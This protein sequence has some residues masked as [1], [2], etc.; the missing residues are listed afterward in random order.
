MAG[1]AALALVA[2]LGP[3]PLQHGERM[4]AAYPSPLSGGDPSVTVTGGGQNSNGWSALVSLNVDRADVRLDS[5][6]NPNEANYNREV[7]E[8][9]YSF[10]MSGVADTH[11]V[12]GDH[13]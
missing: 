5:P 1:A 9:N 10:R 8:W 2:G 7:P 3:Q 4:P 12:D 13:W 6:R 11:L